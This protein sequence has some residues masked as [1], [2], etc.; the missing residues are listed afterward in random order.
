MLFFSDRKRLEELY[1]KFLKE[2]PEVKDCPF[3]VLERISKECD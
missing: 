2:N 1:Q 3:S